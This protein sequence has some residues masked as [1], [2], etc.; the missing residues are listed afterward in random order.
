MTQPLNHPFKANFLGIVNIEAINGYVACLTALLDYLKEKTEFNPDKRFIDAV[1][2]LDK[3]TAT[4]DELRP[5]IEKEK[6]DIE[7]LFK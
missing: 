7:N 1:D 6:N 4:N 5:I 2:L 3:I